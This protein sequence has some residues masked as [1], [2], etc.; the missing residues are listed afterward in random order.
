MFQV[1]GFRFQ[2]SGF[3]FQVSGFRFQ[4]SGFRFQVSGSASATTFRLRPRVLGA[5][6]D[7]AGKPTVVKKATA[8]RVKIIIF[9]ILYIF[10]YVPV[11]VFEIRGE[12]TGPQV[13][14]YLTYGPEP[15]FFNFLRIGKRRFFI[16]CYE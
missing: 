1:S 13:F 10:Q 6:S 2:V 12:N 7:E 9:L 14:F 4:V 16:T 5:T 11:F 15:A 3:R 8:D